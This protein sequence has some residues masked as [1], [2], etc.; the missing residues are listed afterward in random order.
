MC[1][2]VRCEMD[3]ASKPET[4]KIRPRGGF[5]NGGKLLSWNM[6][7]LPRNKLNVT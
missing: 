1:Y 4:R 7:E 5:G 3:N 6:L 2:V